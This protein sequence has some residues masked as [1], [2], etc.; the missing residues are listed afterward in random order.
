MPSKKKPTSQPQ[1]PSADTPKP[2]QGVVRREIL[3]VDDHPITRAGFVGI[4]NS[5]PDL[6]VTREA[7]SPSQALDM[8]SHK[9]P[10]LILTDMQMPGRSGVEFIKDLHS[11]QPELP[12]LVVSMHDEVVYG[13]RALRAGARG[14]LMKDAGAAKILTAIRDVLNGNVHVSPQ[15]SAQL[16]D[17][18][19]GRRPRGSRSAIEILTDREFE[20]FQLIG[21]GQSTQEMAANLHL[22]PK[23]VDVHRG[24]IKEKLRLESLSALMRY[25]IRWVESG[26]A[27]DQGNSSLPKA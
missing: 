6:Q 14:Y 16:F 2:N 7:S 12:I 10:E 9:V 1:E 25:A 26:L 27:D 4:I 24:H 13:E 8:V 17:K 11:I 21:R 23:T 15:M 18:M 3:V 19:T 22:S 20:V 5:Q